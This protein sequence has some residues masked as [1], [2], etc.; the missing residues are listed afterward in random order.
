MVTVLAN[1]LYIDSDDTRGFDFFLGL[2]EFSKGIPRAK[3]NSLIKLLREHQNS[4]KEKKKERKGK[5]RKEKRRKE[6]R[7]EKKRREKKRRKK[8]KN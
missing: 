8:K 3:T 5:K 4:E 6:R 1:T 7:R 2:V